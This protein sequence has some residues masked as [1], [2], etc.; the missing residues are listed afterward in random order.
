MCEVECKR[1][2]IWLIWIKIKSDKFDKSTANW[3]RILDLVN[4]IQERN[5]NLHDC[6]NLDHDRLTD[7][8]AQ[9]HLGTR[10]GI[11][12]KQKKTARL[13]KTQAMDWVS[14]C[15]LWKYLKKASIFSPFLPRV[16]TTSFQILVEP[17]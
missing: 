11:P 17:E 2:Q 16:K 1:E 3:N 5:L 4:R 12:L 14:K 10:S 8:R 9:Y 6:V 7:T 13:P 15:P